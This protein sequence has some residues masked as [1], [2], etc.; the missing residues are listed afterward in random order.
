MKRPLE[1]LVD[2]DGDRVPPPRVLRAGGTTLVVFDEADGS[3]S[4]RLALWMAEAGATEVD[5]KTESEANLRTLR[6]VIRAP[7]Q[8]AKARK[9][10]RALE[11]AADV[12]LGSARPAFARQLVGALL[13]D[14]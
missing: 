1:L 2:S 7:A 13:G 4:S 12:V 8:T 6:I 3:A 11:A 14:R 10:A 5:K 9:R